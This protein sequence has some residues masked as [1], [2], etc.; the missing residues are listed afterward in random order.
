MNRIARAPWTVVAVAALLGLVLGAGV[1]VVACGQGAAT[2][3]SPPPAASPSAAAVSPSPSASALPSIEA[4]PAA[5]A[6]PGVYEDLSG[7]PTTPELA[8][9][10][11][12]AV[13]LDDSPAARPQSGLSD[14]SIV[15]QAPAE[16]GIPRYMAVFQS[17]QAPAIG[18][19]RSAR[20]YFVRWAA[21][22]QAL[23]AHV[24]GPM[25]LRNFLD[26][27]RGGVVNAD[28]MRWASVAF[29]RTTFRRK[30]HNSYTSIPKLRNLA[31]RVGA[32]DDKLAY[33][34][35]KAGVRQPF[36]DGASLDQRGAGGTIKVGYT[37]ER[38]EYRYDRTAN[39]WDRFVDGREHRDPGK[40]RNAG[41]GASTK[42]PA[43]TPTTVV[44]MLVPIRKATAING[45][46][47]GKLE[48]DAIGSNK[49]WVFADGKLTVG[50]WT[51]QSA[52]DRIHLTDSSGAEIVLPRG[53]IFFQV[54]PKESAFSHKVA[55]S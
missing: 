12:I 1:L 2:V 25:P 27:G 5:S 55:A 22:T 6:L 17:G 18:P 13:M 46:A 15:F 7:V 49:A 53:Q 50:R 14:A 8:H 44:V 37:T 48:A 54:V 40:E 20:L 32:T 4:S 33:D 34:P 3:Q 47:L 9:R 24:G 29:P 35:A 36:R 41:Y 31:K 11:P 21:E 43:I 39:T 52:R 23:Y 16:G 28:A 19:V 51:K 26:A 38:V 42:G 45:P 10:Y 30:P